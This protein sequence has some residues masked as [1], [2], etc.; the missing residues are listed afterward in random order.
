MLSLIAKRETHCILRK[1]NQKIT[2]W[3]RERY[4]E[5]NRLWSLQD[6]ANTSP[7]LRDVLDKMFTLIKFSIMPNNEDRK[8]ALIESEW[9]ELE[10]RV[11]RFL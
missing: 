3:F 10:M 2:W 9:P 4:A 6:G 8:L 5:Y 1:Q 7:E 11:R